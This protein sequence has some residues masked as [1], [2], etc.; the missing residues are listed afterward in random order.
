MTERTET[1]AI[2]EHTTERHRTYKIGSREVMATWNPDGTQQFTAVADHAQSRND[3]EPMRANG[4][5]KLQ[6]SE[7]FQAFINDALQS[8]EPADHSKAAVYIHPDST[9]CQATGVLNGNNGLHAGWGDYRATLHLPVSQEWTEWTKFCQSLHTQREFAEFVEDHLKDFNQPSGADMLEISTTMDA[10]KSAE[11]KSATR[12]DN[13]TNT[14]VWVETVKANAGGTRNLEVPTTVQIAVPVI[15][16]GDAHLVMARLRY[17]VAEGALSI[18][19]K[20]DNPTHVFREA[21]NT[22]LQEMIDGLD[23]DRIYRGVPS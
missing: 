8:M 17:R 21:I 1:D 3:P 4:L 13:S 20:L 18:G 23:T 9:T 15:D 7:G 2:A 19:F 5:T 16:G 10:T 11:F 6:S 22:E 12:L 14:L